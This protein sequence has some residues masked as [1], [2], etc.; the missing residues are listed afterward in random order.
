M[1][2]RI[3]LISLFVATQHAV[4]DHLTPHCLKLTHAHLLIICSPEVTGFGRIVLLKGI[5]CD[6]DHAA[7][8][9]PT[10]KCG[11]IGAYA[12]ATRLAWAR[13]AAQQTRV[14]RMP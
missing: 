5:S 12:W 13:R 9:N 11:G 14:R 10:V 6:I 7:L 4:S 8:Q 1:E 3:A 2:S